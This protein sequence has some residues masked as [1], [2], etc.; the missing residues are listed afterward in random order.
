MWHWSVLYCTHQYRNDKSKWQIA[1]INLF[2][3]KHTSVCFKIVNKCKISQS[4]RFKFKDFPRIFRYFQAPYLFSNTVKCLEVF[5]PNSSIFKDFSSTL[6]TLTTAT[7]LLLTLLTGQSMTS[8]C[9]QTCTASAL[10]QW[11]NSSLMSLL[12]LL[13]TVVTQSQ[14]TGSS[15]R[16]ELVVETPHEPRQQLRHHYTYTSA[17]QGSMW[18][19]HQQTRQSQTADSASGIAIWVST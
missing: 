17:A 7:S 19:P 14:S 9:G 12:S 11:M 10:T 15:A 8:E 5:I 3:I 18:W 16:H 2:V 13:M 1:V 4:A 6:W